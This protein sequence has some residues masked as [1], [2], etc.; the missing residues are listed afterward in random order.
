MTCANRVLPTYMTTPGWRTPKRQ[1]KRPFAIQ[2]GDTPCHPESRAAIGFLANTFQVNRTVLENS[3]FDCRASGNH[4]C[5][6][7]GRIGELIERGPPVVVADCPGSM[8]PARSPNPGSCNEPAPICESKPPPSRQGS[9]YSGPA[10]TEGGRKGAVMNSG[11]SYGLMPDFFMR[12]PGA[13]R[14]TQVRR[15]AASCCRAP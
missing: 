13:L 14:A 12:R 7:E 2:V 8:S 15:G 5:A 11:Q 1:R 6:E 9:L 10:Q 4:V 3:V